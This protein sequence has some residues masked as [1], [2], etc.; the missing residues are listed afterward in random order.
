MEY[1][2]FSANQFLY[3]DSC[4][5][6]GNESAVIDAPINSSASFQIACNPNG[7]LN[8][9]WKDLSE[10]PIGSPQF[11]NLLPVYVKRNA[12]K[13]Y[14]GKNYLIKSGEFANFSARM[15]PFNVFDV[16]EPIENTI[17]PNKQ[18]I[19]ALYFKWNTKNLCAGQYKG[20]LILSDATEKIE[21]QVEINVFDVKVPVRETLRITNWFYP[22]HIC[23]RVNIQPWSEEHWLYIQKYGKIMRENRQTDFILW[24]TFFEDYDYKNG[25]YVFDF[26]KAERYIKMYL[27]MGFSYIEGPIIIYRFD[28]HSPEFY[29]KINGENV[30]AVSKKGIKFLT[31]FFES[32]YAFLKKN[33]WENICVQHIGD[34]PGEHCLPEYTILSELVHK[35][36]PGVNVIEALA[37]PIFKDTI[38]I[39]VPKSIEFL[40]HLED[41][42]EIKKNR[43]MWYYTCCDPGGEFLN[44]LLDQELIRSRLLH[45]ANYIY[46]F[47]GYLHWGL[48]CYAYNDIFEGAAD[49]ERGD[50]PVPGGDTHIVYLKEDKVLSS[51]RLEMMR[52]GSEDYELLR[53]LAKKDEK[54]AEIISNKIIRSFDDYTKNSE[55]FE[56]VY[57]ELLSFL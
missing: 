44:R 4:I 6:I 27:S 49:E 9:E 8:I 21:I 35:C 29:V 26:S 22:E 45:W 2:V 51:M 15:A 56:N 19:T 48:N 24:R 38:D 46:D 37:S 13:G 36:M 12:D 31:D 33:G 41:F 47:K 23:K 1:G 7:V 25:K 11:F 10:N 50:G 16:L 43:E 34:E 54:T 55:Y 39:L 14:N 52:L 40:N 20:V 32:W 30:H 53:M 17:V 18:G 3:T 57:K 28:Y 42:N 5:N